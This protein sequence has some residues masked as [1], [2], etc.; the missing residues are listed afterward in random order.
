MGKKYR[1]SV[2]SWTPVIVILTLRSPPS[3]IRTVEAVT[4]FEGLYYT[5]FRRPFPLHS[6]KNGARRFSLSD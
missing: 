6:Q 5:L 2:Q 4:E 1:A 3:T